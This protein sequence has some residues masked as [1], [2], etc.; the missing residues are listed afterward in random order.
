MFRACPGRRAIA[1]LAGLL[2]LLTASPDPSAAET[3]AAPVL[4]CAGGSAAFPAHASP[5]APPGLLVWQQGE[6]AASPLDGAAACLPWPLAGAS[7]MIALAGRFRHDGPAEALAARIARVSALS[8]I[9]YWSTT[10]QRWRDLIERGEALAG[11][12]RALARPDFAADELRPGQDLFFRQVSDSLGGDMIYRVRPLEMGPERLV[13]EIVNAEPLRYL[14]LTGVE[15]G[16]SRLLHILERESPTL[17][18]H[19]LL[20]WIRST[21]IARGMEPLPSLVNRAAAFWRHVSGLPTEHEPPM[22][23]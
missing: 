21:A 14:L 20:M 3:T 1:V 23:P 12:D 6:G 9:R 5:G 10:R 8:G 13:F 19:Y 16:N 4:P 15:T 11:P 22:A 7:T 17:W 18:R 2:L